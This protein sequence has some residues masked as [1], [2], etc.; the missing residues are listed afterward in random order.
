MQND[1]PARAG[2]FTNEPSGAVPEVSGI[3]QDAMP[4][5]LAVLP[6]AD[7]LVHRTQA[8][9]TGGRSAPEITRRIFAAWPHTDLSVARPLEAA[10]RPA[11][12]LLADLDGAEDA[13]YM[14]TGA[15]GG[16][17][18]IATAISDSLDL[19][20]LIALSGL[21][22]ISLFHALYRTGAHVKILPPE[23]HELGM[24]TVSDLEK[25]RRALIDYRQGSAGSCSTIPRT[26]DCASTRRGRCRSPESVRCCWGLTPRGC[27]RPGCRTT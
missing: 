6:T 24:G 16:A 5:A 7:S 23:T 21:A 4:Y 27:R 12:A 1:K 17:K 18:T 25:V 10:I 19:G 15:S 26:R 20:R 8:P 14:T 13:W 2:E 11:E 9:G 22:H 3:G